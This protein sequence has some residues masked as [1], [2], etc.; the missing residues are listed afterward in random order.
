MDAL[1]LMLSRES[2]SEAGIPWPIG[3][4]TGPDFC[5]RRAGAGSWAAAAVAFRGHRRGGS[6]RRSVS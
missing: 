5:Q 2:A 4:G 6:G 1:D 3:R